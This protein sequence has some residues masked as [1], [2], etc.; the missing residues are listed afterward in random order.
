MCMVEILLFLEDHI[1]GTICEI[2]TLANANVI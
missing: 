1:L 2:S